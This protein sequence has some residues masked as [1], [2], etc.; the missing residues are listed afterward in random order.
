VSFTVDTNVLLYASDTSSPVNRQAI[1]VLRRIAAGPELVYLFWPVLAG[2]LRMATHPS[3]FRAP[4]TIESAIGN[5]AALIGRPH[6][7]TP[8]ET[9]LFWGVL[10]DVVADARPTG[11][12][13]PDAHLVALMREN[14]VRTI[15]SR[16]RDLR[17]FAGIEVR[18]PFP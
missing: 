16:D 6:V 10:S 18:D 14:G 2:Y 11:N 1:A 4:L 3:I 9:E 8:G 5:V 12:L 15:L 7:R 17:R 13:M